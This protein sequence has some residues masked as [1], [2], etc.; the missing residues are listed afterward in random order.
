MSLLH[1]EIKVPASWPAAI[2]PYAIYFYSPAS[3]PL[4]MKKSSAMWDL[5]CTGPTYRDKDVRY[6][7]VRNSDTKEYMCGET[8]AFVEYYVRSCALI[9][10]ETN[11]RWHAVANISHLLET[12]KVSLHSKINADTIK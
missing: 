3:A 2:Y 10:T 5:H 1:H 9:R 8:V 4:D 6:G 11:V 12:V 7:Q